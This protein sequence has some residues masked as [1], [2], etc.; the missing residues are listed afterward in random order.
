M[1]ECVCVDIFLVAHTEAPDEV[2]VAILVSMGFDV[3]EATSA[4]IRTGGNG[5][6]RE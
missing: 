2:Q 1:V 3:E 4:L 5:G 6:I